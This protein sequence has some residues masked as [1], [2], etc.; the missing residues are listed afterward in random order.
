M[1][2]S[3]LR[4]NREIR[5]TPGVEVLE[6]ENPVDKNLLVYWVA[7]FPGTRRRYEAR[8]RTSGGARKE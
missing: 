3:L 5:E 6:W 8:A 7:P 1:R 4:E 2:G